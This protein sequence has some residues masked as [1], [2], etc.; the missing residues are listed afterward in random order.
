ML[1]VAVVVEKDPAQEALVD[2]VAVDKV[3]ATRLVLWMELPILVVEVEVTETFLQ[4]QQITEPMAVL[5]LSL[6]AIKF[7]FKREFYAN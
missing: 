2:L 1:V 3:V 5:V 7:K 4:S 6:F